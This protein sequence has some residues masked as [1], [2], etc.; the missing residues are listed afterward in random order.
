MRW[1]RGGGGQ[2]R[3][4]ELGEGGGGGEMRPERDR[5]CAVGSLKEKSEKFSSRSCQD[6]NM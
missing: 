1:G 3:E 5:M 2:R 4:E 6:S